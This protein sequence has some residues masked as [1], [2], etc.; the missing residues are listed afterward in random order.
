MIL[1]LREDKERKGRNR[2]DSRGRGG[3]IIEGC[4]EGV[5]QERKAAKG[6]EEGDGRV[7]VR[8]GLGGRF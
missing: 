4:E 6:G 5:K 3:F 2:E 7:R 8:D 1:V